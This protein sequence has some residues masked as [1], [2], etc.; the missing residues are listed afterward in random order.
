MGNCLS[1]RCP[2]DLLFENT[3]KADENLVTACDRTGVSDRSASTIASAVL[4]GFGL[5]FLRRF[6]KVIDRANYDE[7]ARKTE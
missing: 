3:S 7:S 1:F 6:F 4:Q 5:F 2:S